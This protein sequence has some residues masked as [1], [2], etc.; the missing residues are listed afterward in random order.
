MPS[1]DPI[2]CRI[3]VVFALVILLGSC[4]PYGPF[5]HNVSGEALNSVRGPSDGRYKFAF[6]E[7]GDQGSALDTSQRAAA[8][9]VIRQ[10]QRPLLFVYIHGWMNNANSGD[11]C[12]FEHF[13][14]MISRLPEVTE[15]NI[16][17]IGVYIAWRGKDLTVPGLDLLTF[18]NRKLAGGEV[19]AQNSCLATIN[20]L[21]LAAREPGKKVHHC[22]LMGHSFGG[23]VLSNTISHSILDA[24]STGARN[25]SPWDMAVAF[26][27]ADNSIGT[28][29]LMSEL[30]YLYRYDPTRGAYVGRTP[31]AEEGAVI[32]ENRP[33]FIV[34]QSENDQ[35]TGTFFPIGQNLANT[36]N[37]HYHWDR[38]PVP[39]SGGQKVSENQFQTHT[40]GN[41]K[42]LVNYRVIPLGRAT[43]PAGL[44]TSENRAFEANLR[45][46]IRNRTFL[47]SEHNDGHEKQFCRG[48]EY[49]PDETRPAT[50]KE[51]WRGWEFVY[52]GNARVPCWI[53]RVPKEIIWGHGGL[54]SDNSVAMFAA[55]YRMHF[56]LNAAGLSASSR[57]PTVPKA[58]DIEKLN[59]D[60]VR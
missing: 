47:T 21:A 49:N 48:S 3:A 24:S 5:H 27:A 25:A 15:G 42:Y 52:S 34:L 12:R 40:P 54:W 45:Q 59:Q 19:A 51:D 53:V 44:A 14:D 16:N 10:A 1:P 50:G 22:V 58:P 20:E 8:I 37:L 35:A 23:L 57:R 31:G 28:R 9:N 13:I 39:G 4:A 38:V 36:V 56:P 11:V 32:N 55:L 41:D 46:N 6:I 2:C 17:V 30:E 33:F 43:A 60:K 7:F 26:N 18:W 29:Q